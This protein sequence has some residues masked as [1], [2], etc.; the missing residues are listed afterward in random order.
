M[1]SGLHYVYVYITLLFMYFEMVNVEHYIADITRY[2][3]Y[4]IHI[5]VHMKYK[6]VRSRLSHRSDEL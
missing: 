3:K 5:Y 2:I 4:H 1:Q 6:A